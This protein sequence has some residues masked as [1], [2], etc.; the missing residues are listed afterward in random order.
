MSKISSQKPKSE[1][2]K[3]ISSSGLN[4]VELSI[5]ARTIITVGVGIMLFLFTWLKLR[6][7]PLGV[8]TKSENAQHFFRFSLIFLFWSWVFGLRFDINLQVVAFRASHLR[9]PKIRVQAFTCIVIILVL[10]VILALIQQPRFFLFFFM[11]FV[12]GNLFTWRFYLAK[13]LSPLISSSKQVHKEQEDYLGLEKTGCIERYIAGNWQWW[14]FGVTL[15]LLCVLFVF[16][17]TDLLE[18]FA[19]KIG[20]PST[21]F[22]LA[23]VFVI[24][25]FLFE[26]SIWFERFRVYFSIKK[27]TEL[28]EYTL[29]PQGKGHSED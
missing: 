2:R 24:L 17:I 5:Q 15:C 23:F 7:L 13:Y 9:L 29:S 10:F 27:L 4:T 18:D 1:I 3:G 22:L 12:V 6:G 19:A 25:F 20:N 26:G 8:L 11:T 16:S 21:D 14:R 28:E